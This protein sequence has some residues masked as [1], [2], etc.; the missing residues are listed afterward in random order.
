[1]AE[2]R[3]SPPLPL[4][5]AFV[6]CRELF[7]DVQTHEFIL[8]GPF[9]GISLPGYPVRF[10][11]A[12]Y[13]HLTCGHGA[14]EMKLE[15]RDT[16]GRVTWAWRLP[17]PSVIDP[18]LPHRIALRDMLVDFPTPGQY[19]LV[20]LANDEEIARHALLARLVST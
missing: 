16:H 19:D 3:K 7:E 8:I 11:M 15:L 20:L 1:M 4:A 18:V 2:S 9:S 10:R 6:V 14:Y 12:A 13:A 5:Q 17:K